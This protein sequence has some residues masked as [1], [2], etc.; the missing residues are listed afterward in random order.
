MS[1]R[2]HTT[3]ASES[4]GVQRDLGRIEARLDTGDERMGRIEDKIDAMG[5]SVDTKFEALSKQVSELAGYA[6]RT[7]G[8]WALLTTA[9]AIGAAIIEGLRFLVHK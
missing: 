5:S 2:E 3:H 8:A 9:G 4:P 1:L 7:K 6:N